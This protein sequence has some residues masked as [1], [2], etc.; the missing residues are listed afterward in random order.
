MTLSGKFGLCISMCILILTSSEAASIYYRTIH[1][2]FWKDPLVWETANDAAFTINVL[3]AITAPDYT[4]SSIQIKNGHGIIIDQSVTLDETI[5]ETGGSLI[6]GNYSSSVL[7]INNGVGVDLLINGTME[8]SG[9]F[10][11]SW[12]GAGASWALGIGGT[13]I[14]TRST[15][16]TLWRDHYE[17]GMVSI[18][19]SST[20]IIRKQS[21]D[22]PTISAIN[23]YYGNLKIENTTSAFWNASVVGSKFIGTTSAAVIKGNFEIGT[24]SGLGIKFYTQNSATNLTLIKG[25]LIIHTGS[26]LNFEDA[27]T[28]TGASGIELEGD[29]IV[30]GIFSYDLSDATNNNRIVKFT[31]ST[32]QTISGNGSLQIYNLAND[33]L[34]GNLIL[35]RNILVDNKLTLENGQLE[36]N[37]NILTLQN[38]S[39]SAL[40]RTNGWIRSESTDDASK[41]SWNLG[42]LIGTYLFPFGRDASNYIPFS[43]TLTSGNIGTVSVSTYGTG[44]DNLPFPGVVTNLNV[45][46]VNNSA[47]TVDRFWKIDKSGTSGTAT[48]S[49]SYCNDEI[50]YISSPLLGQHYEANLWEPPVCCQVQDFPNHKV[51]VSNVQNFS[52]W[53]LM[54]SNDALGLNESG[55][56]NNFNFERSEPPVLVYPNPFNEKIYINFSSKEEEI[57][58]IE[59]F[60]SL[61]VELF[62]REMKL[63][64]GENFIKM[65]LSEISNEG[66]VHFKFIRKSGV[67][68]FKLM[69][70]G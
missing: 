52:V 63:R 27:S 46:G 2:G 20:W 8:D 19:A 62:S 24:V 3:P 68:I 51:T 35:N 28:T 69:K 50:P 38:N 37:G 34:S 25:D 53:T 54:E 18:P 23:S 45:N 49:F 14:R 40:T 10:N 31:G 21:S 39:T 33:K 11:I 6:Y 17:S 58:R 15:S 43:L 57:L 12:S 32:N 65:D 47:H 42:N 55:T 64:E 29:L 5:V 9:P 26:E 1:S 22:N 60:N 61:G 36:L 13:I 70:M 7:T 56:Q 41:L 66:I 44:P 67:E 4:S 59:V 16:A 30:N 48:L